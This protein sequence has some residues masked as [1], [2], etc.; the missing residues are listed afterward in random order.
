MVE[1]VFQTN[2]FSIEKEDFLIDNKLQ[3]YYTIK[4][5]NG[6][7]ILAITKDDKVVLTKQFRP[8]IRKYTL[9]L[10]AGEIEEGED[11]EAAAKRELYEETGFVC[12]DWKYLH[13]GRIQQSR[14]SATEIVYVGFNATLDPDFKPTEDIEVVLVDMKDVKE[15]FYT[16]QIENYTYYAILCLAEFKFNLVF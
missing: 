14:M 5:K 15:L 2:W 1:T 7:I 4:S 6:I 12:S 3:P 9:E 8:A 11:S 16:Y 10:P 13:K